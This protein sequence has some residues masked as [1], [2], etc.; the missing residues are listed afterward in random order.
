MYPTHILLGYRNER[1]Q[2]Q[3]LVST[4]QQNDCHITEVVVETPPCVSKANG[5]EALWI[6]LD[7]CFNE[8]SGVVSVS[9]EIVLQKNKLGRY[10]ICTSDN[11]IH[12][13]MP[14]KNN[15]RINDKT[16]ANQSHKY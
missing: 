15:H 13:Y 3:L 4:E 5:W 9:D 16:K 7:S 1:K 6:S 11:K 10:R 14:Y 8:T 12:R 2:L